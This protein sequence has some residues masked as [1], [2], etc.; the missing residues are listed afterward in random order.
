MK[1]EAESRGAELAPTSWTLG[2][3]SGR[4]VVS[5]SVCWLNLR[6]CQDWNSSK[7]LYADLG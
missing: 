1:N 6:A 2:M 3:L 4:G 7:E 5:I